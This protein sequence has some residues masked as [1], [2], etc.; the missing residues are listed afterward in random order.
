M[1]S[2][3]PIL[4]GCVCGL[5]GGAPYAVGLTIAKKRRD[6]SIVPALI[7]VCVSI[8]VIALS[9]LIGFALMRDSLLVFAIT[10]VAAFLVTVVVSVLFYVRKPRP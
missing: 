7:A 10:L 5:L 1:G 8:V 2:V 3:I 9:T 4:A 6:A